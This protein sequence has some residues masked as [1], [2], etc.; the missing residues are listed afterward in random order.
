MKSYLDLLIERSKEL[1]VDLSK[2]FKWVDASRSTY[3]RTINGDTE[4]RYETACKVMQAIEEL[5]ALQEHRA[6]LA[7]LRTANK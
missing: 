4:L 6:S 1:R 3:Y 7:K 5:H 2:A